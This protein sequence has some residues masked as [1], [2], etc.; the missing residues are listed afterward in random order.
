MQDYI[1]QVI[2]RILWGKSFVDV[3]DSEEHPHAFILRSL[4][5]KESNFINYI[6]RREL[7]IALHEGVLSFDQ[8][9]RLYESVGIWTPDHEKQIDDFV[10]QEKILQNQIKDFEFITAKKKRAERELKELK[11]KVVEL[12][13]TKISLFNCSAETRA[14][15]VM[16]RYMTML[17]TE[18]I[19]ENAFWPTE[20]DFLMESDFVMVYN[21]AIAYFKN[22]MFD[23]ATVRKI[24][25]SPAWRVKWSAFK[26]G[27][28][29]FGRSVP[30]WSEMQNYLVYWSQFYDFVF[31]SIERPSDAIINSDEACDVWV[32][33]QTKK[34]SNTGNS[35]KNMFGT[36]KAT[37]HKDHQ[38]QFI[39]VQKGD[40]EVIQKVQEMNTL[41]VR[42]QLKAE[43]NTIKSEGRIS[44]WKLRGKNY[45]GTKT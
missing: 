7:D 40:G 23:E 14:E 5:I 18:D 37:S 38:E 45:V 24:A 4:S 2:E 36:K 26:N 16:R 6:Y 20:N 1:N 8:L 34:L 32:R 25:R 3:L 22:N 39:M 11:D 44:E 13:Q 19:R 43:Y 9:K 35:K 31:E 21:L 42:A 17:S 27:A 41:D 15:E 10:K 28:N 12:N 29:L 33:D 30:D